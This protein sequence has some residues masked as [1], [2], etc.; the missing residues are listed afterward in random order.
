MNVVR[1]D[2]NLGNLAVKFMGNLVGYLNKP[3][4]NVV[5]IENGSPVF[6]TPDDV[7]VAAVHNVIVGL[8]PEVVVVNVL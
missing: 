7:I 3:V 8:I 2:L 1:H 5:S 6:R 4:P